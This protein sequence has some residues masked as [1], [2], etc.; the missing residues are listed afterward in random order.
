MKINIIFNTSDYFIS[1]LSLIIEWNIPILPRVGESINSWLIINQEGFSTDLFF[2]ALT[3]T[4]K[5]DFLTFTRKSDNNFDSSF[6]AWIGDILNSYLVRDVKYIPSET[7]SINVL[8]QIHM[9]DE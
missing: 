7:N 9:D 4:A 5:N 6:K 8:P 3:D 1:D 2:N